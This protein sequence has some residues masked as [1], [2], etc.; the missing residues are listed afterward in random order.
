MWAMLVPT[1]QQAE[2]PFFVTCHKAILLVITNKHNHRPSRSSTR[3][4]VRHT[5][6][7]LQMN[8]TQMD[9]RSLVLDDC[10]Q[11]KRKWDPVLE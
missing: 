11:Q 1:I 4:P 10:M 6:K 9:L 7:H 2:Y 5:G 3:E 8:F